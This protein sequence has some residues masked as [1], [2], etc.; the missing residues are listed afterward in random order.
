MI[1]NKQIKPEVAI[2]IITSLGDKQFVIVTALERMSQ[3]I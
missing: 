3:L 1:D 2:A